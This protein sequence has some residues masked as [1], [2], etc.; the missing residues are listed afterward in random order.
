MPARPSRRRMKFRSLSLPEW[1]IVVVASIS[2]I[3]LFFTHIR[4]SNSNINDITTT[5]ADMVV[6]L[7]IEEIDGKKIASLP[8]ESRGSDYNQ[9][10]TWK[11]DYAQKFNVPLLSISVD[12][13]YISPKFISSNQICLYKLKLSTKSADPI[14]QDLIKEEIC[15]VSG[16]N[17]FV[18]KSTS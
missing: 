6:G 12:Y 4:T 11:V 13:I 3:V 7:R 17:F 2:I 14:V 8:L 10:E 5:N 1:I 18:N 9:V 16:L 15:N